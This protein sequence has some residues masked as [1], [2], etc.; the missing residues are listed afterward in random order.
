VTLPQRNWPMAVG[1]GTVRSVD[2]AGAATEC[3]LKPAATIADYV[4]IARPDHWIKNLFVLP[5][6]VLAWALVP[7]EA[8]DPSLAAVALGLIA[9]AAI[10]SANYVINEWLDAVFD[11]HHPTKSLR[12]AVTKR[13]RAPIVYLEYALLVAFG[14]LAAA[15]VSNLCLVAA[16]LFVLSGVV[17]NVEPLRIKD[18][19]YVDVL[20]ESLNNPIR[21]LIG[22]STVAPSLLPP[23]SLVIAYWMGGGFLM[24]I[25]R[26]A[27]Y[28][29]IAAT[30]GT[31]VLGA[32]RRS[33]RYYTVERLLIIAFLYALLAAFFIAVF[34]IKYRIE[35]LLS[36]PLFAL[37]FTV[38]LRIGLKQGS[39][40]QTPEKLFKEPL[41]LAIVAMLVTSLVVLTVIDIPGLSV[42]SEPQYLQLP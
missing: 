8:T 35:Y 18:R 4:A 17:Y 33:F 3:A 11:A 9:A 16:V 2:D 15:A 34:L 40:A 24:A 1:E 38:Y 26:L 23:S 13:M 20:A 10:S 12:P 28:R 27:E 21:L 29:T 36:F 37:L 32:Y 6:V 39:N 30:D 42:L 5:G 19:P 7:E 14:L 41:L 22:W 25:K 31:A